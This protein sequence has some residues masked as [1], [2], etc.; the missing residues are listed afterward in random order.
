[1]QD[2]RSSNGLLGKAPQSN[3]S[4]IFEDQ[5][6]SLSQILGILF[7]RAS[8]PVSAGYLRTLGDE[9]FFILPYDCGEFI[10]HSETST[11]C[12]AVYV[13]HP[14]EGINAPTFSADNVRRQRARDV[15]SDEW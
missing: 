14:R 9:P 13:N 2:N 5:L 8:L 6:D 3:F 15:T 10:V 12:T 11:S 7:G 4:T 1:M